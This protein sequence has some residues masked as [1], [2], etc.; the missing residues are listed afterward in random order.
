MTRT[1]AIAAAG[2]L[3]LHSA[4]AKAETMEF[5][6]G[7]VAAVVKEIQQA[8]LNR[9][10]ERKV[11]ETILNSDPAWPDR[12]DNAIVHMTPWVY[13]QKMRDVRSKDLGAAFYE[14]C[15]L[16]WESIAHNYQ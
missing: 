7:N 3:A 14:V 5:I 11:Q 6:C 2:L 13:E 12:F 4:P 8:R 16:N 1:L 15:G 10:P 9:V